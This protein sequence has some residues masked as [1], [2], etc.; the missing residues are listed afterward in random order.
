MPLRPSHLPRL[1]HHPATSTPVTTLIPHHHAA[2]LH[3][4]LTTT[5]SPKSHDNPLNL[6]QSPSAIPTSKPL[7]PNLT[8]RMTRHTPQPRPL[9]HIRKLLAVSSAKGGVG[10]STVA[11]NVS[12]ALARHGFSTGLLDTDIFG[13][14]IPTLFGTRDVTASVDAEG[15]LVPVRAYGVGTMSMGYLS[16]DADGAVVAWR[17]LM[18]TKALQQLVFSVAWGALDVL[19]LDLPP[20]T[21]DTQLSLV[22]SVVLHGALLVSTP[23]T[24]AV[25]DTL[26]GLSFFEKTKVPVLGVVK[27]MSH[28]VCPGCGERS[29]VFKGVGG[30]E[31]EMRERG[32]EVLA[33]VPLSARVC[34]D[35][36]GGRPTV[37]GDPGGVEAGVYG[38]LAERLARDLG[39]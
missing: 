25:T 38:R 11:A 34:A 26:R 13:P 5:R 8:N 3:R 27:N 19:V 17:G 29:E 4:H 30:M 14:S 23:Q 22:Q 32:A 9:P 10:K 15:R 1:H 37:V 18:V 2:P 31:E 21:G 36:D 39:L 7:P 6:P 35:A 33:E 28:F 16:S 24:L 20:G 12:L